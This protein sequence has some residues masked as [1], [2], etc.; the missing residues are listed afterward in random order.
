MKK[1]FRFIWVGLVALVLSACGGVAYDEGAVR[2]VPD[3][4]AIQSM[5]RAVDE[6][7]AATGV[8][9]IKESDM[10][11]D[12]FI[13]YRVD[14]EKIVPTYISKSPDNAYE[15]GGLF[16]YVIW[17]AENDPTIK[18]VDLRVPEKIREVNMIQMTKEYPQF[19][20]KVA[21]HIYTIDHKGLAFDKPLTVQSP[22]SNK[23]LPLLM[24]AHG[25]VIVDYAVEL[26]QFIDDNELT[27]TPGEDIRYLIADESMFLPAYSVP[28]TVDENNE[29]IF[30][31]TGVED[32]EAERAELWEQYRNGEL[33][34]EESAQ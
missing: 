16:Q 9:P 8:L 11:M 12:L 10:D 6:Y 5:Q 30:M 18:L 3:V 24:T 15:Q 13:K 4:D 19:G 27:P 7:Q 34:L 32:Y 21:E 2:N 20:E 26:Q 14:F 1:Q 29:V 33:E 23:L 17:D 31:Y 28:Y 25:N 22:Y